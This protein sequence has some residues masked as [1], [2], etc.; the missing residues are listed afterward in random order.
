MHTVTRENVHRQVTDAKILLSQQKVSDAIDRQRE[1]NKLLLRWLLF[2][3][4]P[5]LKTYHR[6]LS[7]ERQ[8]LIV[9]VFHPWNISPNEFNSASEK[10]LRGLHFLNLY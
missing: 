4:H 3:E 5:C 2:R 8:P 9:W 10:K 6:S 1:W 7:C